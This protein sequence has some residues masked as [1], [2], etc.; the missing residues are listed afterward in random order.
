M[1]IPQA[2]VVQRIAEFQKLMQQHQLDM[3]FLMQGADLFYY[4]GVFQQG[5]LWIP[6][7]GEPIF[8][9]RRSYSGAKRYSPLKQVTPIKSLRQMPELL[10]AQGHKI[11][12]VAGIESDVLPLQQYELLHE[13]F[14]NLHFKNCSPIIREQRSVKSVW[15]LSVLRQGAAIMDRVYAEFIPQIQL[16]M[17]ELEISARIEYLM[18]SKGHQGVVRIRGMSSEFHYG[19]VLAGNNGSVPS[20]FDGALGGSGLGPSVPKG[21]GETKLNA[22]EPLLVDYVGCFGGYCVDTTLV[23]VFGEL[24][25]E[26]RRAHQLALDIQQAIMAA[27]KPGATCE[28]VYELS[29]TLAKQGGFS[30]NFMGCDD[31]Q[32]KFVGHGVGIELNE[33]PVLTRNNPMQLLPNMVMAIEPK[34]IFPGQGAVGTESVFVVTAQGLERLN[35]YEL[36]IIKLGT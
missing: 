30:A 22:N 24:P 6:A 32:V 26:L 28:A 17:T 29:L 2:E 20:F 18:R 36:N 16:G 12:G 27:A 3:A 8:F 4:A 7:A 13:I 23:F 5:I 14:P 33:L 15:E 1:T 25:E 21:A 35:H 10:A 34:F 11:A 31:T 9:V 19:L